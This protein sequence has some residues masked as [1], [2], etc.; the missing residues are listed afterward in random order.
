MHMPV[1][2]QLN[3]TANW[4][5]T[6]RI[7]EAIGLAA[8]KRGWQCYMAYGR[9]ANPSALELIKVGDPLNPYFHYLQ[10]RVFDREGLGSGT[11]TSR[12]V[13]LLDKLAPDVVQLHNI[14]DHWLNYRILFEYLNATPDIKVV[15]TFHDC[16][17][18]TG[19]CFHF[20]QVGCRKW[21]HEC[22]SCPLSKVYPKSMVDRSQRNFQLKRELFAGCDNL[23]VVACSQWMSDL[24]RDSFLGD[25]RIEVL[26]NGVDI[27]VFAPIERRCFSEYYHILAVSNGWNSEKGLYDILELRGLLPEEFEITVVGLSSDQI[28]SLPNGITGIGR[29]AC[30]G[31]LVKLY[32]EADVLVN[33]SHA[34]TFPTVNLEALSCGTPVV[35]YATGGSPEAVDAWTGI[36]VPCSDV[37]AMAKALFWLKNTPLSRSD[38]RRR[39]L[40]YFDKDKCFDKYIDLYEDIIG[41]SIFPPGELQKQ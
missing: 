41:H 20:A 3:A 35:T 26:Y 7:A 1:L 31:D 25:K 17:A 36:I 23:T 5:S 39:A 6:G 37:Q 38:C 9:H 8:Q 2:F 19:H 33:T 27:N 14:H 30:T 32:N 34:D 4:G 15:W 21:R 40:K 28:A 29:V 13:W 22:G 24:V 11:A 18:F 10:S 16:W 12:V